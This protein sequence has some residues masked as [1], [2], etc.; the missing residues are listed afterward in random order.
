[1][2]LVELSFADHAKLKTQ[3][4]S[5]T[6][7]KCSDKIKQ[8]RRCQEDREDFT[9]KDGS[10][11]P[12]QIEN[13]GELFGFCPGK[14]SWDNEIIARYKILTI[15]AES[16]SINLCRGGINDQPDWWI[17][18]LSWFLPRYSSNQFSS[19]AKMILGDGKKR[20]QGSK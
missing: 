1:M 3:G 2:A 8:L 20:P 15:A 6:C 12:I 16:G 17:D 18:A 5:F 11:W 14:A 19:R 4:R 7:E 9:E 13:G 10:L